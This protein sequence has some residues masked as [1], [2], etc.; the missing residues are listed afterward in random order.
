MRSTSTCSTL[1][2]SPGPGTSSCPRPESTARDSSGIPSQTCGPPWPS[3]DLRWSCATD[4]PSEPSVIWSTN[5]QDRPF[6][7]R[8]WC[9]RGRL[10]K[11]RE[12]W[13]R[14]LSCWPR[15]SRSRYKLGGFEQ[16]SKPWLFDVKPE[17]EDK[18]FFFGMWP[19]LLLRSKNG[20]RLKKAKTK[21]Q[22]WIFSYTFNIR[23]PWW[24][25]TKI[26]PNLE[27][28]F[29]P[30]LSVGHFPGLIVGAQSFRWMFSKQWELKKYFFFLSNAS[31]LISVS[32]QDFLGRDALP[33][34]GPPL[35]QGWH[36]GH[37]H[38]LQEKCRKPGTNSSN[39][40]PSRTGET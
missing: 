25:S 27:V 21:A 2:T 3:G 5:V 1:P 37:L 4:V 15:K 19:A 7:S 11:R 28:G 32:G 6:P 9:S 8:P 26:F 16:M 39:L 10:P 12:M 31:D 23:I 24:I 17:F 34:R 30:T 36:S 33:P 13:K 29:F 20:F 35:R 18:I 22:A 14:P 38:Q 40:R